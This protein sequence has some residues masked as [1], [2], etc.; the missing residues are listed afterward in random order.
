MIKEFLE[1]VAHFLSFFLSLAVSLYIFLKWHKIKFPVKAPVSTWK[2]YLESVIEDQEFIEA[3]AIC[4]LIEGK[5]DNDRIKTPKGYSVYKKRKLHMEDKY[6]QATFS[7]DHE[8]I[9]E[10]KISEK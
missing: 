10:R 3:A 8:Y 7:F 6:E 4:K 1:G 2:V 5:E 9:I